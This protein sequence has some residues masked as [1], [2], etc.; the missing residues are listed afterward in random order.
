MTKLQKINEWLDNDGLEYNRAT[1]EYDKAKRPAGLFP[2]SK[3][4]GGGYPAFVYAGEHGLARVAVGCRRFSLEA[5]HVHWSLTKRIART[6]NDVER[7]NRAD[8]MLREYLPR[9]KRL[10]QRE[11]W[12]V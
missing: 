5:A 10:A 11:G 7:E 4:V 8:S 9:A 6:E 12:K 3:D 2:L 1:G